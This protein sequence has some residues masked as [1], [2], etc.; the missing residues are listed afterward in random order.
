M[1]DDEKRTRSISIGPVSGSSFWRPKP[2]KVTSAV[3]RPMYSAKAQPILKVGSMV[4]LITQKCLPTSE[5]LSRVSPALR[6]VEESLVLPF[7][8]SSPREEV[9]I[10]PI[11]N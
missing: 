7:S 8:S 1:P 10:S 11:L 5:E 4:P 3:P 6:I 2:T 9:L